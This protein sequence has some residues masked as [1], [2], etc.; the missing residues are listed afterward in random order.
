MQKNTLLLFSLLLFSILNLSGCAERGYQLSTQTNTRTV[1]AES[2]VDLRNTNVQTKN[3]LHKMQEAVKKERRKKR[4]VEKSVE[5]IT[6]IKAREKEAKRLALEKSQED[7]TRNAALIEE[8]RVAKQQAMREKE[9]LVLKAKKNASEAKILEAKIAQEKKALEAKKARDLKQAQQRQAHATLQAK[10]LLDAEKALKAQKALDLK[11]V[12]T[13]RLA[14]IE[15]NRIRKEEQLAKSRRIQK[16]KDRAV[17][18]QNS[19]K[20]KPVLSLTE[21]LKFNL[22]NKI[23]HKFGSS[24]VHG[25]VIYLDASGQE[26]R[27]AQSKVYL[28]PVSAKLNNWYEN[29]YLKNKNN[30]NSNGTVANYLNS[31]YLNL[32][33]NFEFYGVAEGSYYVIIESKY[34]SYMAKD[35]KVYIAKRIQVGKYKKIMA[36]FSKKL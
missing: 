8:Q 30:S 7:A 9:L 5:T 29:Y 14:K 33:K 4:K 16:Q 20:E 1:T 25:H 11:R 31:T 2:S 12:E 23:Y 15:E 17:Q 36:V 3:E 22:I 26:T 19:K 28:L 13:R 10:K 6:E 24:E 34:P 18:L 27:L 35:K 21:P 32:E